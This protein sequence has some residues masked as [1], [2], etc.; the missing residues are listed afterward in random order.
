MTGYADL[1]SEFSFL[2]EIHTAEEAY[3]NCVLV[4]CGVIVT[5]TVKY[6]VLKD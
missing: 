5:Q 6:V 4:I 3:D 2:L 1:Y